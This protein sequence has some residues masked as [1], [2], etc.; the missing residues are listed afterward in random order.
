MLRLALIQAETM[1][2]CGEAAPMLRWPEEEKGAVA[3]PAVWN[4]FNRGR[5]GRGG[6]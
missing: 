6:V 1:G 5:R 4:R 2:G 3:D